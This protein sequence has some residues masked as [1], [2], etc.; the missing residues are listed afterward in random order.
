MIWKKVASDA[1]L[2][3]IPETSANIVNISLLFFL[4]T[5]L[6]CHQFFEA[7]IFV[8]YKDRLNKVHYIISKK[9]SNQ[10][11]F[12]LSSRLATLNANRNY[13]IP[14]KR[15]YI[16]RDYKIYVYICI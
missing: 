2:S 4:P 10:V 15:K 9:C 6:D 14:Y 13:S 12:F 8:L 3:F 16:E 7:V 1:I 5:F 11:V